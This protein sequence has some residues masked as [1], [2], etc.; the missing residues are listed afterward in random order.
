MIWTVLIHNLQKACS[1]K[2]LMPLLSFL[3][4]LLLDECI[5][6][7]K[8]VNNFKKEHKTYLF[9]VMQFTP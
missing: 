7:Q 3:V 1:S 6:F 9:R 8:G 2:I 5:I 4:N